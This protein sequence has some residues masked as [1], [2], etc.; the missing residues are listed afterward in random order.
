MALDPI[1]VFPTMF[2]LKILYISLLNANNLL[3]KALVIPD[4]LNKNSLE[5]FKDYIVKRISSKNL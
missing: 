5:D 4:E 1:N 3:E 2:Q